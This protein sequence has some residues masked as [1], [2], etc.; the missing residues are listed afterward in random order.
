MSPGAGDRGQG[1]RYPVAAIMGYGW[2]VTG[3]VREVP[4][5]SVRVAGEG[6]NRPWPTRTS[7]IER[8]AQ[9]LPC[10]QYEEH[11]AHSYEDRPATNEEVCDEGS[12][13]SYP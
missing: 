12:E 9:Q 1:S 2:V 13:Q 8:S 3:C 7:L 5:P 6:R 4:E 11:Y 10:A